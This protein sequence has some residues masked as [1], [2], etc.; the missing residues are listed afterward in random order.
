MDEL[1]CVE[2]EG[3]GGMGGDSEKD[4]GRGVEDREDRF[5]VFEEFLGLRV[6]GMGFEGKEF[7]IESSGEGI[8]RERGIGGELCGDIADRNDA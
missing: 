5:E 3:I 7:E 8:L 4:M 6:E 1:E 2:G